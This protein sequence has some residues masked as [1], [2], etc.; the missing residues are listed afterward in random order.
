MSGDIMKKEEKMKKLDELV[1]EGM[2]EN[3]FPGAVLIVGNSKKI[4]FKKAYGY[5][6][7][8]PRKERNSVGT[9]YDMASLTKVVATTP[10]VMKLIENAKIRL[11]DPVHLFVDGFNTSQKQEIRIFHLLTHTSGLP[12]Y[13]QA[14][15]YSKG[16]EL[17]K[18]VNS[19]ETIN[20][21]GKK[22]VYSC[23][24]F[25]TLMEI[26]EKVTGKSFDEFTKN[27]IF[28]PLKMNSTSFVPPEK[29][30]GKIAP[31]SQ[32]DGKMLRGSP[33]DE[34][35]YYLGGVSGNAG[36]FSNAEDVYNYA[37]ML[38]NE[39]VFEGKRMFS[40]STINTFTREAFSDG[41]NRRSLG[42]DMK[43]IASSSG[44]LMSEKA[45]GHTGFTGTSLWIDPAYDVIIIFFT[46]RTHISR[47]DNLE[48]II[49]F[50]PRLHNYI[51]SHLEEFA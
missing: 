41:V 22:F 50:R 37:K 18:N 40:K 3:I 7:L 30:F 28:T 34:L 10:A 32:R 16:K 5:R 36:L 38:I 9:I 24:N 31:T 51:I 39:G 15:R 23:L 14:W 29:W 11:Y 47:W 45:Y 8:K 42:W 44:D 21:V 19:V 33:D 48:K 4:L 2:N 43:T 20:P 6:A 26:V 17:L 13:S 25:I 1:K 27:E 49:R 46:N 12:P 35:A